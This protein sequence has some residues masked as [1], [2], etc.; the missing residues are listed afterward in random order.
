MAPTV[1]RGH[2]GDVASL[3]LP[4]KKKAAEC[5]IRPRFGVETA[6]IR[7]NVT[8]TPHEIDRFGIVLR[9]EKQRRKLQ[10]G[11]LLS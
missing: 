8:C 6:R 7:R 4:P 5:P 3:D 1:L 10:T 11:R 9:N 2:C